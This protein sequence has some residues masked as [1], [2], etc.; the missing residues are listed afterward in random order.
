MATRRVVIDPVT[1]IEGHLRVEIEA[2]DGVIAKAWTPCTQFRGLEIVLK[3]RDPRDAWVFAQRICGVCTSIHALAAIYAVEDALKYPIP[4]QAQAIRDM[5]AQAQMVQDHVIHFYHLQALDWVNVVSASQADPAKAAALGASLSDWPLNG[6]GAMTQVKEQVTRLLASGQL[7]IFTNGYWDH[8]D[9]RLPPEANLMALAHYLQALD[10]QRDMIKVHTIFGGKN[11]HPNFLVGGMASAINMDNQWTIN[12]VRIDIIADLVEKCLA[13]VEQ[14]YLP[15]VL[16]IGSFYKDYLEIGA[17]NPNMLAVGLPG[18]CCAGSPN[19]EGFAAGVLLDGNY[20]DVKP[21]ELNKIAEYVNSAWYTYST[22]NESALPP[23]MGETTPN[24]TGPV[25]PFSWLSDQPKYSW[26]KIPRYDNYAMQVGPNARLLV[27][28]AR[29]EPEIK[30]L[31]DAAL[32]KLGAPLSSLNSTMGRMV[33]RAVES[34]YCARRYKAVFDSF[35]DAIKAGQTS[36]FNPAL[37]EP[38]TWPAKAQGVGFVEAP[39]GTLS[40]WVN[41]ENGKISNYQAIVPSTWNS[42]GTDPM[43]V[44][45]PFAYSLAHS[46]K[47]PLVDPAAPLE[48][49]RTVHSFDPCMSCAVHILDAT[50]AQVTEVKV[51]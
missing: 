18:Y 36:T 42:S 4:A 16:A 13:F 44:A 17:A 12:Q 5:I 3:D 37:W 39:R 31:V 20:S 33:A 30:P 46:G 35:V 19:Q 6:V 28:Y 8:P 40:H 23:Y 32:Q 48:P 49:L 7:S 1:R 51:V 9:Y 14:V 50:G 43:G 10:W 15:D 41:I 24:Y 38:A 11:P 47:H 2:A 21:F 45:G 27:A 26:T 34:V 22:G 25:P 29:N